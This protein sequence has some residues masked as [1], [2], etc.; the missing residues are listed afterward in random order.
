MPPDPRAFLPLKPVD[1]QLLLA[2]G[3]QELHGYGLV[4][5]IA[6]RT[7]GLVS[8]DPGNLYRVIK[9]LL[10]DGLVAESAAR[11]VPE[12]GEER[13]R[14]YRITPLGGRVAGQE[15][16]RLQALV[17]LPSVRALAAQYAP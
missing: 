8:L 12:L 13:R 14:Y 5:A 9:R 6:D 11:P 4:Q 7:D 17:N 15:V 2:L 16:R 10:A 3:E 1:L